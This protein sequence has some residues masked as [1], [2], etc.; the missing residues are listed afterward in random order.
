MGGVSSD[1]VRLKL[2]LLAQAMDDMENGTYRWPDGITPRY[3][4]GKVRVDKFEAMRYAGYAPRQCNYELFKRPYYLEQKR[5]LKEQRNVGLMDF[6][7]KEENYHSTL[8]DIAKKMLTELQDRIKAHPETFS[9]KEL[10]DGAK[11]YSQYSMDIQSKLR[12][13][14]VNELKMTMASPDRLPPEEREKAM[15]KLGEF[16][17][18]RAREIEEAVQLGTAMDNVAEIIE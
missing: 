13:P 18:M 8:T 3:K 7:T 4:N 10:I 15:R 17:A 2:R 5:L 12:Q 6:L 11:T 14:G 9:N 1:A 16:R